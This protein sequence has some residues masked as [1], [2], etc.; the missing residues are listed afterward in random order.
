MKIRQLVPLFF[1]I[2]AMLAGFGSVLMSAEGRLTAAAQLIML[3]MILDGLDGTMARR[4]RAT[5]PFGAELDTFV[6]F[7]SFGVAPAM[8]AWKAALHQFGWWGFVVV[9]VIVVA[10]ASRLARF[11]IVDPFRGQRGY[12]GLPITANA[13][14]V[15]MSVFLVETGVI[16]EEWFTLAAGPMAAF[17]WGV[18]IIMCGLEVSHVHYGKPT[19]DPIVQIIC[20]P[21]VVL[22]FVEQTHIAAAAALAML[23]YGFTYV[24]ITPWAHRRH[25]AEEETEAFS[26]PR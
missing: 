9:A 12:L 8:L 7:S 5:S 14:W 26:S 3:S 1:T 18:S 11:R 10:G 20:I 19:K 4:L 24:F 17:V 13:G 15:A 25:E 6:D 16:Q 22:L 23:I 21:L 2:A